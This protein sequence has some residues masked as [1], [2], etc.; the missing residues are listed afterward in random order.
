MN[1]PGMWLLLVSVLVAAL[2]VS[3][4][5]RRRAKKGVSQEAKLWQARVSSSAYAKVDRDAASHDL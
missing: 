2:A 3:A 5:I 1:G 4:E